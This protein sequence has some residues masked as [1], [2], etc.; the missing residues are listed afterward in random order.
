MSYRLACS[1][2]VWGLLCAPVVGALDY[3]YTLYSSA[4]YSDNIRQG[5]L[6]DDRPSGNILEGGIDFN[7]ATSADTTFAADVEGDFSRRWYSVD[8][9]DAEDR[10]FLD[11][12]LLFQPDSSNFRLAVLESLRQVAENRR[13]ARA[14]NNI[15]DVNVFS[16]VPSYFVDLTSRSR[17][18]GT[19]SYSRIDEELDLAT[20]EVNTAT[21]GY[22]YKVSNLSNV[23]LNVSQ[24]DIEFTD[25]GT[26]YDQESGFFRWTYLGRLTNW[27][28]D[29]GQQRIVGF[30]DAQEVLVNFSLDRQVSRYST[31]G[32]FYSQ[33]YSDAVGSQVGGRLTQL[34]P[35]SE[36]V[37]ADDLA[38]E[39]RMTLSYGFARGA[40]EGRLAV[41][42]QTLESE[43]AV[44]IGRRVDEDNYSARLGLDY[45]FR[46]RNY[47]LSDFG[48]GASFRYR[49]EEF[50]I[51]QEETEV[52]E[53]ALR[54]TYFAT[55]STD[56]FMEV[57]SR[58]AA[59]TAPSSDSDENAIMVGI[60]FSPRPGG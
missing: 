19:Y 14:V 41:D 26:Q 57:R 1:A 52:N 54:L 13:L 27:A 36:A 58:N 37:Y 22:E 35:N 2:G 16:V 53:A 38:R 6:G 60:R 40:I 56:L 12:G 25:R 42:A 46:S 20:R 45:R 43:E 3:D 34:V 7:V 44:V 59:G 50:N 8:G 55:R 32:L 11:A 9:L 47:D 10:K 39:Q 49:L 18:R 31:L 21:V 33:G 30:D 5:G 48:I 24:S 29:L 17:I 23:S 4:E 28:L 15:R 51:T